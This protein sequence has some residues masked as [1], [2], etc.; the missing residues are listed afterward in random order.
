MSFKNA[1]FCGVAAATLAGLCAPAN[2]ADS[3]AADDS[4]DAQ[5][6]IVVT[7]TPYT[8]NANDLATIVNSVDRNQ[9][10]ENG[11]S[12]LADALRNVPGVT[13][14][15]FAAGASR[16]IIRGMDANRVR[17]LEDGTSSSDVSD[18]GPDHG[19]P[20]DPLSAQS[21]EVVRGAGT[22]RYG[23]QAI[24]GVINSINNRVPMSLPDQP[25]SAEVTSSY[26]ISANAGSTSGLLD[27]RSGQLA[28]HLD[29]FFRHAND[30]DTPLGEQNNSFSHT[31]GGSA[32]G[33]YFFGDGSHVGA[34][35]VRYDATYGIPSDVTHIVMHQTK[36]ISRSSF[37]IGQGPFKTLN[38]DASY[39][40]Y[41]HNEENP[42]GSI[43]STFKNKEFDGRVEAL[44]D[45]IGP[46]THSA[47]GMEFQ[48]RKYSALGEDSTYLLPT[49]TRSEAGFLFTEI[50]ISSRLN[51]QGS[52]R[53]EN[54][55]IEGTSGAIPTSVN[56]TPAS[57]AIG[58]VYDFTDQVK[59]GVTA[60]DTGRAPGVVELFA[61]GGHDGP[62][63]YE[64]G[65]PNLKIERAKSLEATLRINTDKLQFE[66]AVY[67]SWFSNYIYGALTGNT[68]NGDGVCVFGPSEELKELNYAQQN[69]HFRGAEGKA[70]YLLWGSSEKG[71][72]ANVIGDYVRATFA[73][74][75]NVP[76]IPP[77]RIGGGLFWSSAK[78]DASSLFNYYGRQNKF[79]A[80]D[81]A[82]P[83]YVSFDSQI[84]W[85]PFI[86][87][88]GVEF[89][90]IGHNLTNDVQR[91]AASFN[92]DVVVAPGRDVR[93]VVRL[94]T[95]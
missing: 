55:H 19:V 12:N 85:R 36:A 71:L 76:R 39:A 79:G 82:T 4:G 77:Y 45:P 48:N 28:L 25:V 52:A 61:Q 64:T 16:P 9:I 62:G 26:S 13:G 14:S 49:L 40:D 59:L 23:S 92:K 74:G 31:F 58:L 22:L 43:V 42:D 66:S 91:N 10:I 44:L 70:S 30:Y 20:I 57:G 60:S 33:S 17:V 50:P 38:V 83:S 67:S 7:A 68:C 86:D 73:D 46:V 24:G 53:I 93:F 34:A 75:T 18:I 94:A 11:G 80:F 90:I 8:T 35:V 56:F 27:T 41:A 84:A 88:P 1:C 87:K 6:A 51:M 63:T 15:G 32:G 21:I 72:Y 47:V 54:V 29:G 69:A 89:A 81:A 2:A 5:D 65:D 37:D 78:I 95:M 3:A